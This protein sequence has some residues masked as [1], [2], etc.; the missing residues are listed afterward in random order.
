M[1]CSIRCPSLGCPEKLSLERLRIYRSPVKIRL[2]SPASIHSRIDIV[3][4][5]RVQI[6]VPR[7]P[8]QVD[9]ES[10]LLYSLLQPLLLFLSLHC[11]LAQLNESL[12]L[13]LQT[14]LPSLRRG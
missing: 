8:L 5:R 12:L 10:Q 11:P 7:P 1:A 3:S 9:I 14:C 6:I 13:L 4:Q 2:T